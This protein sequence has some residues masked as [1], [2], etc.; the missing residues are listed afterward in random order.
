MSEVINSGDLVYEAIL[1]NATGV[2]ASEFA[3][4]SDWSG[5]G[6]HEH[7]VQFYESDK[8]LVDSLAGF[9]GTGLEKGQGCIVVGTK[10]HRDELD[11]QLAAKGFDLETARAT[12]QYLSLD[13]GETLS[14]F[15]VDGY[16]NPAL[17]REVI[18]NVIYSAGSG[19]PFVRIFGEMVSLLWAEGK[20]GEAIS[21]EGLWNELHKTHSFSLLC[22]YPLNGFCGEDMAEPL[23]G[24]CAAHSSVIPT[25]SYTSLDDAGARLRAIVL[26]Q[27]KARRL[28]AEIAERK[29]AEAALLAMKEQLEELLA[30]E[31]TARAEAESAS[32]L[33]DEFLA[34][35]SHEL[36]TPLTAILGWSHML[37]HNRLNEDAVDRAVETI[38]RN[39]RAQAQ[40]VED[41]L[42]VSRFITGNLRLNV[43][44]VDAANIINAAIDSVQLAADSK[45][46][47]LEVTL[48][49]RARRLQ[50]DAGRLQQV[51]W[52]LLSNAIKFT[53]SGGQV[54][55]RLERA[56]SHVQIKVSD[57]GQGISPDFLP[58]IFDRFR[59]ADASS[60][61]R[62]G[63]LG[64]GLA[65]VR[66]LVDLH[67]GTV[68]VDSHGAGLG[69]TFTV[70]LPLAVERERVVN[71]NRRKKPLTSNESIAFSGA[72]PTLEGVR[73][74]LVD[75]DPDTLKLLAVMLTEYKATV[76][77]ASSV[78]EALEVFEWY[79]PDVLIS[80]VAMPGEDGYSLIRKVRAREA[81]ADDDR[82][83]QA[84]A[85][86]AYARIDDRVR[87]LSA[88]FNMFV[89][90]PVEPGELITSIAALAETGTG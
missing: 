81:E 49:P 62:Q 29:E 72:L 46:I 61:R 80:D 71:G 74:L 48:D 50:G 25:E 16:P 70:R 36:R 11:E 53:P 41:I 22:G 33:K 20:R 14:K 31:Q 63:G 4:R 30:R 13:A 6:E 45:T 24:V 21:L 17:F 37:R 23:H 39:A 60:T 42:D 5:I 35:V 88:G 12:G 85:L 90:K 66:H 51:V 9:I 34:T 8:F 73:V 10:E 68:H 27:Q 38:E 44:Y 18:G 19:R 78:A 3:P 43:E 55:V 52:N 76:Q 32:R 84:I 15:T 89:P 47:H 40:L 1:S 59:Q 69:A 75:D 28:E 83:T 58:F 64:L 2:A 79:R 26:L 86:T 82:K 87:A 54:R 7:C 56:A 67:G 77:N 57:S 65:I